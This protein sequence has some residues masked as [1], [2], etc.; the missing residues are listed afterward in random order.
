MQSP[1]FFA[2]QKPK[3]CNIQ[4][5]KK[6]EIKRG[7]ESPEVRVWLFQRQWRKHCGTSGDLENDRTNG[8]QG[9]KI[10]FFCVKKEVKSN[11]K[12]NLFVFV[13]F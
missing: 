1:L 4:T 12:K 7:K 8:T 3:R 5:E 13:F 6:V 10:S 2:V 9:I 11:Q